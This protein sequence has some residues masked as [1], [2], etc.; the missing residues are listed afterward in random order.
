MTHADKD[1]IIQFRILDADLFD[2]FESARKAEEYPIM[3]IK[4]NFI[5]QLLREALTERKRKADNLAKF[6]QT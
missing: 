5:R 3:R 6:Q 2:A 4:R 1:T